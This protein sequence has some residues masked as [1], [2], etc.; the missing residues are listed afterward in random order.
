MKGVEGFLFFR[1]GHGSKKG[2]EREVPF[3]GGGGFL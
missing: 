1:G 3:C 2:G